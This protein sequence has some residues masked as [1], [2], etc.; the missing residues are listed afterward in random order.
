M[1]KSGRLVNPNPPLITF[2]PATNPSSIIN[3]TSA[4]PGCCDASSPKPVPLPTV[5][6][7]VSVS[8]SVS[9]KL[10]FTFPPS[11]VTVSPSSYPNPV[12]TRTT[13]DNEVT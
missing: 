4:W 13:S 6:V 5:T 11:T 12:F 8:V 7:S 10:S 2:A 9:P 3:S 1:T